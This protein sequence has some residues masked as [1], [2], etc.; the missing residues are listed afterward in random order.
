M[1]G[2]GRLALRNVAE[3]SFSFSYSYSYSFS[4]FPGFDPIGNTE[5]EYG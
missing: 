3:K 5:N 1:A 2:G 4:V